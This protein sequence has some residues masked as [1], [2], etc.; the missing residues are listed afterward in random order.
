MTE[1]SPSR[2]RVIAAFAAVY[3]IWGSTYLGIRVA[4]ET[5]PKFLMG[6]V[7]FLIAGTILYVWARSRGDARPTP[8]Q[9]LAAT[10][11]GGL[12]LLGGNGAVMW[13]A[14][15]IPTG[16]V[17]LLV[18]MVPLWM[19]LFEWL[20]PRKIRPT[21]GVALGVVLGLVGLAVLAGPALWGG[22]EGVDPVSVVVL[23][24]GSMSWA[25]GS[26]YS[27]RSTLP[28]SSILAM[29]MEMLAGGV[30]LFTAGLL[31]GELPRFDVGAVSGRSL[32]A[33]AY[34][35]AFGSLIGYTAY[36]W[37][38]RVQPAARVSTYA[39]VNP[40]VAVFLGWLV[41]SEPVTQR[42][43]FAGA[44]IVGSVALITTTGRSAEEPSHLTPPG[45]SVTTQ[46]A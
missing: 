30:L 21:T 6:G 10:I 26:L 41:L 36:I 25:A 24:L 23:M 13:A 31:S 40:I 2:G 11:V 3:V 28:S 17:S 43:L 4:M 18:A 34:L 22:K 44:I 19:V 9:W 14:Q 8:R 29:G 27:R 20:G 46:A 33:M 38:M 32:V 45:D 12:L 1:A 16:I 39:Y 35:V 7:R 42:T 5:I 15:F 37:L